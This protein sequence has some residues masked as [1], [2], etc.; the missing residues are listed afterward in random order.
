[1]VISNFYLF[2]IQ[3]TDSLIDEFDYGINKIIWLFW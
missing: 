1:M 2:F 3:G